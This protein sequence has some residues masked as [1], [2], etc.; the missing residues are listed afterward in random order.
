MIIHFDHLAHIY[1][2]QRY[3]IMQKKKQ[4]D[5]VESVNYVQSTWGT[6]LGWVSEQF[7]SLVKLAIGGVSFHL[8]LIF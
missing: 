2:T 4:I 6:V 8:I 3:K 7:T 5:T 1:D